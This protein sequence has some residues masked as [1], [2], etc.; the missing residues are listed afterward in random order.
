MGKSGAQACAYVEGKKKAR[1]NSRTIDNR[2]C[3]L[4]IRKPIPGLVPDDTV[5]KGNS[6]R[7][8]TDEKHS[9]CGA[10]SSINIWIF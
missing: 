7:H 2:W 3:T 5:H 6:K 9:L 1:V 8:K 10:R 4:G